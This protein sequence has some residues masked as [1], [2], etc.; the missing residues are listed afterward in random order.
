MHGTESCG[1][2]HRVAPQTWYNLAMCIMRYRDD[3]IPEEEFPTHVL[4]DSSVEHATLLAKQK[5]LRCGIH[6]LMFLEH[7]YWWY[8][9]SKYKLQKTG[10]FH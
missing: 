4:N 10:F 2:V 3:V 7:F 6:N 1:G 5:V 8:F 9:D